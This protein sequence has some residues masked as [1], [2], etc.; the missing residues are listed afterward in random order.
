MSFSI[1]IPVIRPSARLKREELCILYLRLM[2][3]GFGRFRYHYQQEDIL[4]SIKNKTPRLTKSHC[5][6]T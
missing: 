1:I 5:V 4:I 3:G 6:N 2:G